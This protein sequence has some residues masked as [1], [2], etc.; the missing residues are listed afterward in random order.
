MSTS[1]PISIDDDTKAS[2]ALFELDSDQFTYFA[3]DEA[4]SDFAASSSSPLPRKKWKLTA[5]SIW[6]LSRDLLPYKP[7]RDGRNKI[8]YCLICEWDSASLTSACAHLGKKH[9]I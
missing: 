1:P 5:T 3:D 4:S 7:I 9:N 2:S 8:W 6:S